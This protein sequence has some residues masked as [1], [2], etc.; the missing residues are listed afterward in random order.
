MKLQSETE[1]DIF[2]GNGE[3][4]KSCGSSS[5]CGSNISNI[6]IELSHPHFA[7]ET[8]PSIRTSSAATIIGRYML[9]F[10]G[11]SNSLRELGD[12]W[13]SLLSSI[14]DVCFTSS[15]ETILGS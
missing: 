11:W 4:S 6:T 3:S 12:F 2:A 9:V 5:F 7:S 15:I 14:V 10:G 8:V 1:N 13:V